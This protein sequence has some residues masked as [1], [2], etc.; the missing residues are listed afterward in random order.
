MTSKRLFEY[1]EAIADCTISVIHLS[2]V[3]VVAMAD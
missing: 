2:P 3:I 1:R